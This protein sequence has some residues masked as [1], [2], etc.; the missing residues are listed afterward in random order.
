MNVVQYV[1]AK[2][3]Q[4]TKGDHKLSIREACLAVYADYYNLDIHYS[5]NDVFEIQKQVF[6]NPVYSTTMLQNLA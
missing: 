2:Y 3:K 5:A 4:Q 1:E 6:T